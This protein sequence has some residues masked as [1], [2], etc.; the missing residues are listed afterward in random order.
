MQSQNQNIYNFFNLSDLKN[1]LE[2]P[3][4]PGLYMIICKKNKKIYFGESSNVLARLGIHYRSLED[5]THDCH[6]LQIFSFYWSK[7]I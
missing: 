2:I 7:M 3:L 5:K 1:F 4:G 6:T